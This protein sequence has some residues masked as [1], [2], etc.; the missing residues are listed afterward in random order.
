MI[1]GVGGNLF[2]IKHMLMHVLEKRMLVAARA[3]SNILMDDKN[4]APF[5]R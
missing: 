1:M 5:L 3:P 2:L 4:V